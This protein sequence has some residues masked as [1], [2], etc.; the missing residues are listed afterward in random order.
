MRLSG[1]VQRAGLYDYALSDSQIKRLYEVEPIETDALFDRGYCGS[2]SYR[3]PSLLALT[4]GTVL[5]GADQRVSN[6]ND[7]PNDI[8]FVVRRSLT[9]DEAGSR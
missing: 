1:E 9:Q 5:A 4:S 2:A 6:A 7:S 8:N 3:I